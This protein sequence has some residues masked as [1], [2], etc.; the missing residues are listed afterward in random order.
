MLALGGYFAGALAARRDAPQEGILV[1]LLLSALI[2]LTGVNFPAV[3]D[4]INCTW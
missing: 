1:M 3:L 2:A 4:K